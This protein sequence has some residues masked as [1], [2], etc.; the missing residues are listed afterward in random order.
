MGFD[1]LIPYTFTMLPSVKKS[2]AGNQLFLKYLAIKT[3]RKSDMSLQYNMLT[4]TEKF[5]DTV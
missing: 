5:E 1:F 4:F 2:I 3:D